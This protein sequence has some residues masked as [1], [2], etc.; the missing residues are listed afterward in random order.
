MAEL[1]SLLAAHARLAIL[2]LSVALLMALPAGV[3]A[4]RRP[5]LG[6]VLV[7]AAGVVQ[8]VPGLALLALMVPLL[9]A[10]A[11]PSIGLLPAFLGLTLYG[12]LPALQNTVAGLGSVDDAYREAA[13]G[14]GMSERQMLLRVELP[15]ALPVIVAGVRTAAVWTVGMATL[16]TP[17]GAP[18]LGNLIFAGLQTR[19]LGD[20]LLGCLGSAAL[21]LLLDGLI[22]GLE[23]G[24]RTRR[25]GLVRGASLGLGA[26][27]LAAF[28]PLLGGPERAALRIGAKTFTEQYVLAELLV[29]EA[30][31]A[32]ADAE[33]VSSLGSTVVFDALAS[34]ELD[35]YVDYSG[36]LWA[37]L[38]ERELGG[39]TRAEV[40]AGVRAWL[41]ETHGIEV[42]AALGFENAYAFAV[43]RETA[44]AGVRTLAD[45][46]ARSPRL[47]V[48]A[49]YELFRREEWRAVAEGYGFAFAERR[50]M[51]PALLYEAL[52]RGDVDTIGAFGTDGRL[53]AF[54]LVVLEDPRALLPPYDALVLGRAGLSDAFP[55]VAARLRALAGT[56]DA[57]AMRAMNA[58]VDAAGEPPRDVARAWLAE[59]SPRAASA[60]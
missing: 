39:A 12:V 60:P 58:S 16:S 54:D 56:I 50:S 31:A 41:R 26:F 42:L 43:R 59:R 27:V 1:P 8:T 36:T 21:A 40:L 11:L 57:P 52:A 5:A 32:G 24:A 28:L 30:E 7:T 4:H 19:D 15:L 34:G 35:V 55:A 17:I 51:D 18:S 53:D 3:L 47:R 6:R 13:R 9:A 14:V 46:A 22:R 20:V 37:T 2:S 38:M 10:L 44:A 25:P 33:V 49:D 48:G 23:V 45:L 29:A